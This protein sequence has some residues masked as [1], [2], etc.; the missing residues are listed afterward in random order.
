MI[1]LELSDED[2]EY[3]TEFPVE[4]IDDI[5]HTFEE[6]VRMYSGADIEV[7]NYILNRANEILTK[8]CN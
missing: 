5:F 3:S 2:T 1:Y 6:M 8:N 4:D 7:D